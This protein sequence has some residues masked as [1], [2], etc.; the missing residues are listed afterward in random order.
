MTE[1]EDLGVL[2]ALAYVAFVD[3]LK[4]HLS[5]RY[6]GFGPWTGAVLRAVV[7]EPLSLRKLAQRLEMTS[8]GALKIVDSMVADG[9]LERVPHPTDGRVRAIAATALGRRLLA[10]ARAF[11]TRFEDSLRAELGDRAVNA[12]RRTLEQ[13]VA[14]NPAPVPPVFRP[15]RRRG[16][17][18]EHT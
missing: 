7:D 6:D 2:L 17:D 13:I 1:R 9:Y 5:R 12:A 11:H 14:T 16:G 4:A 10:S 18:L 15:P 3:D 8:A